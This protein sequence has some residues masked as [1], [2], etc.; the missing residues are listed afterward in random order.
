MTSEPQAGLR[1]RRYANPPVAEAL[2]RLRWE[3]PKAWKPTT[4]GLMY[5][6]VR[7]HYPDEPQMRNLVEAEVSGDSGAAPNFELRSGPQQII[8]SRENASRLLVV[9][10][11]DL[12]VHGLPPYEG[13]ESLEGRLYQAVELLDEWAAPPSG[14]FVGVGLRYI[15][16]IELPHQVVDFNDWLTVTFALPPGL[17]QMMNAFLDRVD[18]AYPDGQSKISFTWAST[19]APPGSS[20]FVLDFDLNWADTA[21]RSLEDIRPVI[22]DLKLKEG[23]AFESLL[24]DPLREAFGEL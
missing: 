22:S 5:G 24:R 9:G 12:S 3:D 6:L 7:E 8:F 13:W 16:R 1:R 17:P 20:A 10:P 19:E 14:M 11:N 2:V 18:A 21:G 15:N 4:P 23:Q